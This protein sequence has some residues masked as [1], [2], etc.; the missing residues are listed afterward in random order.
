MPDNALDARIA[1]L[2]REI[3]KL[4]AEHA[5]VMSRRATSANA[6]I[7]ELDAKRAEILAR[8]VRKLEETLDELRSDQAR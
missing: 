7:H 6:K 8:R 4:S 1:R 5:R 2:L 3:E